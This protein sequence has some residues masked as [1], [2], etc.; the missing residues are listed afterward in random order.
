VNFTNAVVTDCV[1]GEY[2]NLTL[3][4]IKST[5][6]YKNNRMTGIVL[7]PEIQKKLGA[8]K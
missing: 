2:T 3:E 7:P 8:K 1:L 4:Q 5:W 6:N